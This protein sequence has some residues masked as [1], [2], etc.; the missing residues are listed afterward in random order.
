MA[1]ISDDLFSD[2]PTD[3]NRAG[4]ELLCRV[5]SKIVGKEPNIGDYSA[6]CGVLEAFYEENGL[7]IPASL[8]P[9]GSITS[10]NDTIERARVRWRLQYEAFQSEIVEQYR[11]TSKATAKAAIAASTGKAFG[12]AILETD[13]KQA[14]HKHLE[15]VRSI[16]EKSQLEDRKKNALFEKLSELAVEVN[17]NGTRTDRFFAFAGELGCCISQL[18]T[19]AKAAIDETKEILKIVYR[20]RARHDGVKLPEGDEM[21]LLPGTGGSKE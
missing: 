7:K 17:R 4:F 12:Y 8:T 20:A 3:V 6:A 11:L 19:N 15:K 14:I 18:T 1:I 10:T 13:E 2:L 21:L 16:I 9:G 5:N